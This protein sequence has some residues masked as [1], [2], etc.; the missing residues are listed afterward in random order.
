M[1]TRLLEKRVMCVIEI[2]CAFRNNIELPGKIMLKIP[3]LGAKKEVGFF[4][5]T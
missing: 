4:V 2:S 5:I 3:A 1:F